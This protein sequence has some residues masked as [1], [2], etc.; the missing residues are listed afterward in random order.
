MHKNCYGQKDHALDK[1]PSQQQPRAAPVGM[2]IIV[3]GNITSKRRS[4]RRKSRRN[5]EVEEQ[6]QRVPHGPQQT[7]TACSIRAARPQLSETINGQT[8]ETLKISTSNWTISSAN[9]IDPSPRRTCAGPPA[10]ADD[11]AY[12]YTQRKGYR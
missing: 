7:D 5:L 11:S 6:Q 2:W 3:L 9:N 4:E 12:A 8:F 1:C 10:I